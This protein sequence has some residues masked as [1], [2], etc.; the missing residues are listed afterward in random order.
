MSSIKRLRSP[1][2]LLNCQTSQLLESIQNLTLAS[3]ELGQV[4]AAVDADDR[5]IALDVKV[6]VSVK[7]E[8]VEQLLEVVAGDL[9]LFDQIVIGIVDVYIHIGNRRSG[10]GAHVCVLSIHNDVSFTGHWSFS[11]LDQRRLLRLGSCRGCSVAG[12]VWVST[13]NHQWNPEARLWLLER[14]FRAS[15]S[16]SAESAVFSAAGDPFFLLGSG[17]A[18]GL[19]ALSLRRV[20]ASC[21]LASSS[22]SILRRR[23][24]ADRRSRCCSTPS[25]G[26]SRSEGTST[27]QN[28]ERE[29]VQASLFMI[30]DCGFRGSCFALTGQQKRVS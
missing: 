27:D 2:G 1:V 8:N 7:I 5:P 6:D 4:V 30:A 14:N 28:T 13:W 25:T 15:P 16:S 3:H 19:G 23:G 11:F 17:R 29:D 18:P 9:A 21:F 24:A 10:L 12:S 26:G 20:I 22:A